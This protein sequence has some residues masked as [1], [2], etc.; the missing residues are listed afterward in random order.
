MSDERKVINIGT[1]KAVDAASVETEV[2]KALKIDDSSLALANEIVRLIKAGEVSHLGIVCLRKGSGMSAFS[3]TGTE[4][5]TSLSVVN[6]AIDELKDQV[7][8]RLKEYLGATVIVKDSPG[9]D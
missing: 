8:G 2:S 6:T 3:H 7:R 9:D 1:R 5:A 4:T